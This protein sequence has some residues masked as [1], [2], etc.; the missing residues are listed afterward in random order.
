MN[1]HR[2]G[3]VK[4]TWNVIMKTN[5][6][7]KV[8]EDAYGLEKKLAQSKSQNFYFPAFLNFSTKKQMKMDTTSV[9]A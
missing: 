7:R 4:N 3:F 1:I 9:E 8:T 2:F 6:S 5:R